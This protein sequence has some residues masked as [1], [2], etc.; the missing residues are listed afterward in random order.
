MFGQGKWHLRVYRGRN[1]NVRKDVEDRRRAQPRIRTPRSRVS[2]PV[3]DGRRSLST[4]AQRAL[5][6]PEQGHISKKPLDQAILQLTVL[7]PAALGPSRAQVCGDETH[8]PV[9]HTIYEMAW[10]GGYRTAQMKKQRLKSFRG[11]ICAPSPTTG[12]PESNPSF[13]KSG[14]FLFII[15]TAFSVGML[16]SDHQATF[17]GPTLSCL[18]RC[19]SGSLQPA[20]L[21]IHIYPCSCVCSHDWLQRVCGFPLLPDS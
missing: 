9:S 19:P 20:H 11:H 1:C 17:S 7:S 16:I 10:G 12:E 13:L 8:G 4:S 14:L 18:S 6:G 21:S 3:S 15:C 2:P 5:E